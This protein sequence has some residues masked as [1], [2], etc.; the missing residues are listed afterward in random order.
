MFLELFNCEI[1]ANGRICMNFYA[2]AFEV[3]YLFVQD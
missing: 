2:V 1:L 3:F